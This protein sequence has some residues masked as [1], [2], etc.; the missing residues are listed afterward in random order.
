M[1]K[2]C[3]FTFRFGFKII[4][5]EDDL[6]YVKIPKID[7]SGTDSVYLPCKIIEIIKLGNGHLKYKLVS[8][9]GVLDICYAGD[10]LKPSNLTIEI[11]DGM[12][13]KKIALSSAARRYNSRTTAT[14]T[15]CACKSSCQT[16]KCRC[17]KAGYA[18][19]SHCH[20]FNLK[21]ENK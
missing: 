6:V 5:K 15:S 10:E 21:C 16:K 8:S 9:Y 1:T 13:D 17:K 4:F 19:S 14:T 11:E 18:C 12:E 2:Y 3:S 20:A 7:R